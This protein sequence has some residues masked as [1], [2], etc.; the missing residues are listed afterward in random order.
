MASI[1]ENQ[2]I[3]ENEVLL[4]CIKEGSRL[5]IR[6][7]NQGYYNEANCQFP[8]NIRCEGKYYKVNANNIELITRTNK[9]FYKIKKDNITILDNIDENSVESLNKMFLENLNIYEDENSN[10][11]CICLDNEKNSIFI[12]CGHY[13]CCINCSKQIKKCPICRMHISN[14]V[15]KEFFS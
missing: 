4:K 14:Y 3:N 5:R 9:W 15:S 11:C 7:V 1:E 6:I 13:Y 10:E 8:K 12:P 2:K